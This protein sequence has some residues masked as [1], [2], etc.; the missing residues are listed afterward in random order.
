MVYKIE[1][2]CKVSWNSER[3]DATSSMFSIVPRP[4]LH[5]LRGSGVLG[6]ISYDMLAP[7]R[8]Q[9]L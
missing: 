4:P 9:N 5:V 1:E 3:Q 8:W 2:D 7:I 6:D